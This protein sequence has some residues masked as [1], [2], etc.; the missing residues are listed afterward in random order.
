MQISFKKLHPDAKLPI[1]A[2]NGAAGYDIFCRDVDVLGD[3][4]AYST[5]LA[6]EIPE[7]YCGII[8][9]RSSGAFRALS[10]HG[11]TVIDSDYRGEI[12]IMYHLRDRNEFQALYVKDFLGKQGKDPAMADMAYTP[13]D[14]IAQLV[15]QPCV[16][17]EPVWA[18]TLGETARG[19][20]GYGSTGR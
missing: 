2:S 11:P 15:V 4:F 6:V 12:V 9:P 18:E 7:G 19:T 13:G 8:Y 17:F 1:R 5:G 3:I 16:R 10:M 14:R 20:G